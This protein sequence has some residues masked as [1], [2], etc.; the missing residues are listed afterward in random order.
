[1][2]KWSVM[3]ALFSCPGRGAAFF[4]PLRRAGTVP[5]AG[6]RYGPGSAAHR[7]ARA[8]R[9]A[10]SGARGSF[11]LLP[12]LR[13]RPAEIGRRG[14]LADFDDAAADGAGA[15]KMLEQRRAIPGG[16]RPGEFLPIL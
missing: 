4:M 7:F 11:R 5:D 10:A 8:T 13:V 2:S 6:V 1:M 9:C 15:G 16:A 12:Q 3:R 14:I